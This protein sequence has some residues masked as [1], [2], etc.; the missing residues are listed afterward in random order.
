M[1]FIVRKRTLIFNDLVE[2][3]AQ[4]STKGIAIPFVL[5]VRFFEA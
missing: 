1:A 4:K 2:F 5:L 3:D